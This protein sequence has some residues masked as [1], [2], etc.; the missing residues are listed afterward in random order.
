M[1][2]NIEFNLQTQSRCESREKLRRDMGDESQDQYPEFRA[3]GMPN[4]SLKEIEKSAKKVT[5]SSP[6]RFLTDAYI[7]S[8]SLR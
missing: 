1:R 6:F 7:Y 2:R 3:R 4:Y 8:Y 5:K